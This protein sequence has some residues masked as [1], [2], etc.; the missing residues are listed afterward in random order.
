MQIEIQ[1]DLLAEVLTAALDETLTITQALERLQTNPVEVENALALF[2][3]KA[4]DRIYA[5]EEDASVLQP[6]AVELE[7]ADKEIMDDPDIE[8]LLFDPIRDT[9]FDDEEFDPEG[10]GDEH[11]GE[12]GVH[13]KQEYPAY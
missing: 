3:E 11:L 7:N 1:D 10:L 5:A 8:A 13:K 9:A 4:L 2:L 12:M 6:V